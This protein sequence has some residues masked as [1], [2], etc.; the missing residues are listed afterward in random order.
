MAALDTLSY[1]QQRIG[2]L[3]FFR[4]RPLSHR[5]HRHA[6]VEL[7]VVTAGQATY[8]AD[9]R[10][11]DLRRDDLAWLAP[12]RMHVL[13]SRS[14]DFALWVVVI[15]P[16]LLLSAQAPCPASTDP[17]IAT[18]RLD[19]RSAGRLT[20]LCSELSTAL[21]PRL[22]AGLIYL[23]HLARDLG[24]SIEDA[25][26]VLHPVVA[27]A[28]HLLR[29]DPRDPG[30]SCLADR[31]GLSPGRFGRLFKR[32]VGCSLAQFRQRLCLERFLALREGGDRRSLLAVALDAG[33]GSYAQFH[34]VFTTQMG[35]PP[36]T[37]DVTRGEKPADA[38]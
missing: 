34:R 10:R 19:A 22:A 21:S 17:A 11:Y 28:V 13:T 30:P 25:P 1:P 18:F 26:K 9:D 36:S 8:L 4:G 14:D 16:E 5:A 7:N 20:Q 31:A 35:M 38:G 24:S 27:R 2:H 37:W 32:E 23:A 15:R 29:G 12:G 33:F 3:W 6:E